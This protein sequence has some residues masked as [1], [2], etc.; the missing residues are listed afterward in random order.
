M[1]IS[2]QNSK[3]MTYFEL[4]DASL[5]EALTKGVC[6]NSRKEDFLGQNLTRESLLS[7]CLKTKDLLD[8]ILM[9]ENLSSEIS[10]TG[11]S[12]DENSRKEGLLTQSFK[13]ADS[14]GSSLN[15][16]NSSHK[17]RRKDFINTSTEREDLFGMVTNKGENLLDQKLR[18]GVL[19]EGTRREGF[20][21]ESLNEE[22]HIIGDSSSKGCLW[23]KR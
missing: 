19:E 20:L 9:K 11:L 6:K 23:R 12:L 3:S 16:E 14:S 1:N 4:L 21:I 13:T 10:K 17:R 15:T 7:E 8:N 2:Q 18:A 22:G 5:Q